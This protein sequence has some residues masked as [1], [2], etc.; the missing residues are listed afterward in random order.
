MTRP[1]RTG[2]SLAAS[3][4]LILVGR[5]AASVG[6]F[7]AVLVIARTLGPEGRG[8]LA[9][10]TIVSLVVGSL[11]NLGISSA[12]TVFVPQRPAARPHLLTN[13]L[14]FVTTSSLIGGALVFG[15]LIVFDDVG[16]GIATD[17]MYALCI[18][19]T[20]FIALSETALA[21][22]IARHRAVSFSIT[23]MLSAW[24]YAV[25]LLLLAIT[26]S[27]TVESALIAWVVASGLSAAIAIAA[28][29]HGIGFGR[30]DHG[31][32]YESIRFGFGA[33]LGSL[34]GF[35][36]FRLDQV[37]MAYLSTEV[38]LG[39][40]AISVNVSEV[41]LLV[42]TTV[43]IVLTPMVAATAVADQARAVLRAFRLTLIVTA[44]AVVAAAIT[45]P[46][47]IP[48]VFGA[49]FEASVVPF[50]VLLPGALGF[51][52]LRVF[53]SAL[54]GSSH[55]G[56]SSVGPIVA[57]AVGIVLDV[58]LIPGYGANGAAAAATIGFLAGGA[59][60]LGLY[61][62]TTGCALVGTVPRGE[63]FRDVI[64][65]ARRWIAR[66]VPTRR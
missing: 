14:V 18:P 38:A 23:I 27:I 55:P 32:L 59:T 26:G 11:T 24:L 48:L 42:P 46:V 49:E 8:T 56:R 43:G 34:A 33:W 16:P 5:I 7:V 57:L 12:T 35:L 4:G 10:L 58:L 37:L 3:S 61:Q 13:S 36:N 30:P 21:F 17:T 25:L 40:Y 22:I 60:A 6:F 45:G 41:L 9:F 50:L 51:V 52:L 64:N 53:S 20:V 29:H 15:A 19:A 66:A 31:L 54:V 44:V 1:A 63:D 28:A 47:L 2:R 65:G 39:F 62:R